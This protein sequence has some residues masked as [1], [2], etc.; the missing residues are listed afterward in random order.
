MRNSLV[1]SYSIM[2]FPL[3]TVMGRLQHLL[4]IMTVDS[5]RLIY[6][7]TSFRRVPAAIYGARPLFVGCSISQNHAIKLLNDYLVLQVPKSRLHD[8]YNLLD[9]GNY[10][11]RE[12][13]I[14]LINSIARMLSPLAK[15]MRL[16][17]LE[18]CRTFH[19][20]ETTYKVMEYC[21]DGKQ[22]KSYM[23]ALVAGKLK[24]S[25]IGG[26]YP[27][28]SPSIFTSVFLVCHVAS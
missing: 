6:S 27:S 13:T 28:Y 3:I 8:Q 4:K 1:I 17:M 2:N 23:W 12:Y 10:Y 19:N 20:D 21:E 15:Y 7:P 14:E 11:T 24:D 16:L 18:N 25:Q 26:L 9:K 5:G 22:Q